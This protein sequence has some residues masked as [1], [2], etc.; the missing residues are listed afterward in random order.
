MWISL[1]IIK[2][3]NIGPNHLWLLAVAFRE[4]FGQHLSSFDAKWDVPTAVVVHFPMDTLHIIDVP[5][6]LP[7]A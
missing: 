5:I 2:K 4:I 3:H 7:N 6:N 1:I